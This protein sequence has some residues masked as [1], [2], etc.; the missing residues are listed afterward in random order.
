MSISEV[1][2][3][4]D[5]NNGWA[6]AMMTFI[7][8]CRGKGFDLSTAGEKPWRKLGAEQVS[9]TPLHIRA[10]PLCFCCCK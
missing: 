2:N 9:F 6:D 10:A 3:N 1:E 4:N 5:E 7:E 8:H